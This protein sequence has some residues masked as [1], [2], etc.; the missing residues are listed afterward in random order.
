MAAPSPPSES[1]QTAQDLT[2]TTVG[3]FAI[4][5]RLGIGGMGEVYRAEDSMLKRPVALK[6]MAAH[7]RADDH[8][9]RR[10]LR[11]AERAS[12][13]NNQHIAAVYDVLQESGE[14][15]LVME[16]VEGTTLRQRLPGPVS[17][18]ECLEVVIQCA[19]GLAAAQEKG[20][21]HCDIKPENIMLTPKGHVKVLD[22]GVAKRFPRPDQSTVTGSADTKTTGFSGTPAYMAPEVLLEKESVE[23]AD[24]FSLG[25]VF[26]EMLSGQH[27]FLAGSFMATSDRILH[28][29]PAPLGEVNRQI[30]P[31]L[32][33]I[34]ARMLVKDPAQRYATA[35]D[36]LG[37][38][39]AI[40]Q[41]VLTPS[42][43]G[44]L[45][46]RKQLVWLW[47]GRRERYRVAVSLAVLVVVVGGLWH[48]IRPRAYTFAQRD[49]VLVADFS[50]QTE[51]ANLGA[52]LKE[53]MF[54]ELE[55]SPYMNIVPRG[56]VQEALA[57]MRLSATSVVDEAVGRGIC[58][59][60][61]L[62]ALLLGSVARLGD[63][64]VVQ[65]KVV[66]PETGDVLASAREVSPGG[67]EMLRAMSRIA[68]KLR[69]QVGES[70]GSIQTNRPPLEKV[71]SASFEAVQQFSLGKQLLFQ[72]Q[73]R[74]A[75]QL[76]LTALE[77]DP[78]F[79][80]AHQYAAITYVWLGDRQ[81]TLEHLQRA[82]E[83]ADQVGPRERLKI[84]GD[85]HNFLEQ[86]DR[87]ISHYRNLVALYPDDVT[88]YANMGHCYGGQLQYDQAIAA[89]TTA[90]RLHPGK[91]VAPV[92]AEQY[93]RAGQ[94]E[95]AVQ[96]V[97]AN[98]RENPEEPLSW[99][100]L[101]VYQLARG[102]L[103]EAEQTLA[104]AEKRATQEPHKTN[105]L[106]A[107]VDFYLSQG[108]YREALG[109]IGT[110]PAGWDAVGAELGTV[111]QGLRWAEVWLETG[112][113]N[114]AA[115]HLH[116]LPNVP[117]S[118]RLW[119]IK[120]LLSARAGHFGTAEAVLRLL[121]KNAA[122][123]Q[124]PPAEARVLQL[125]A[126][127]AL[128]QG[129]LGEAAQSAAAAVQI[130][131]SAF[132]LETLARVQRA[133]G[134]KPEAIETYR[135]ILARA[136]ERAL[137]DSEGPA[138]FFPS[139]FRV[140]RIHYE[141]GRLLEESG[142]WEEARKHYQEFL[143]RWAKADPELTVVQDLRRRLGQGA[144]STPGGRV[145]T[146]AA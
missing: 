42:L 23:R 83:L 98:V 131:S 38:L 26:Y 67:E 1:K 102:E 141:L 146:P 93:F 37:D 24:I 139:F 13:L 59:R 104:E 15:F 20:V 124:S 79:A 66:Q 47:R 103:A 100:N 114:L 10:F 134:R 108:R 51:E 84:L 74:E 50:N 56:R 144:Q 61:G 116:R 9:R 120:G 145:P 96:L 106:L 80:M 40:Q 43:L 143:R 136:G 127:I 18:Q 49:W 55:Q 31:E 78:N 44:G 140:V 121:E 27:P 2:G 72:R 71:T 7:L 11:E 111:R 86:Y 87:A 95:A 33:R 19:E 133:L 90:F 101:G 41:V 112:R 29:E 3:R 94:S 137:N 48:W 68:H 85:Y 54:Y 81:R 60:E 128:G 64:Y 130:R 28:D 92:L 99:I 88:G 30:P 4:R 76:F 69:R 6:R 75:L 21:V 115:E 105:L 126:E 22:F 36:L 132:A 32:E 39:R 89:F 107:K 91:L 122:I 117:E 82:A 14:I 118:P 34:V 70:R 125:R 35:R 16:F 73:P 58:A 52:T 113:R 57:R 138:D 45:P 135:R 17:I 77:R 119:L 129:N 142:E 65:V 5:A 53:L 46:L 12:S 123:R 110:G 8:Y 25:V 97:K 62:K 63:R 109:E